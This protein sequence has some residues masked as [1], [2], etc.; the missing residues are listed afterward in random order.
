MGSH[1]LWRCRD[2]TDDSGRL[3]EELLVRNFVMSPCF[4]GAGPRARLPGLAVD[5]IQKGPASDGSQF[6]ALRLFGPE[7]AHR[8]QPADAPVKPGPPFV[9]PTNCRLTRLIARKCGEIIHLPTFH[10]PR[11]RRPGPGRHPEAG[12]EEVFQQRRLLRRRLTRQAPANRH[13]D[14]GVL[15]VSATAR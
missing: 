4:A 5:G 10:D 12:H 3:V 15:N 14:G 11:S 9:L 13:R 7:T 2:T 6:S 1:S 8:R